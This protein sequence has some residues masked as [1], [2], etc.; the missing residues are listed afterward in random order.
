MGALGQ[1]GAA[2]QD[3]ADSLL[4]LRVQTA[5]EVARK[6]DVNQPARVRKREGTKSQ[7]IE[8]REE[9]SRGGK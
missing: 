4:L 9:G 5:S 1:R 2:I 8:Y 7:A 3:G 6:F